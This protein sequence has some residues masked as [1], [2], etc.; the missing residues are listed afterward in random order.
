[1][2]NQTLSAIKRSNK[3]SDQEESSNT[4]CKSEF[5][6]SDSTFNRHKREEEETNVGG[7]HDF[8]SEAFGN[9]GF[10]LFMVAMC[11]AIIGTITMKYELECYVADQ[12][13][14][15]RLGSIFYV[16][17][18]FVLFTAL[19][20]SIMEIITL[21]ILKTSTAT[22]GSLIFYVNE[23]PFSFSAIIGLVSLLC[24]LMGVTGDFRIHATAD[25]KTQLK[26][27]TFIPTTIIFLCFMTLQQCV[28]SN[29]IFS[30]NYSTYL[31]R[32]KRVIFMDLFVSLLARISEF[33][34]KRRGESEES[35]ATIDFER[36]ETDLIDDNPILIARTKTH[37]MKR[38][39]GT[40]I[41][42]GKFNGPEK[43]MT[44]GTKLCLLKEFASLCRYNPRSEISIISIFGKISD[45]AQKKAISICK[46]LIRDQNMR[47]ISDLQFIFK[48]PADFKH[49]IEQIGCK[50]DDQIT[51]KFVEYFIEKC[52]KEKYLISYSLKQLTA[53]VERV[54]VFLKVATF[55]LYCTCI[56]ISATSEFTAVG[57]MASAVFGIPIIASVVKDNVINPI[58][59]LFII[60]PYDVGDRVM[61]TLNGRE[62]NLV[63]SEL[64]VFSTQFFRWDGTSFFVPNNL[65]ANTAIINVRRSG[66]TMEYHH[67]QIS[68]STDHKKVTELK[69]KLQMFVRNH[70]NYFTDYVLVNYDRVENS[71][72]LY[73]KVLMQYK[74]NLQN[75][76]HY[77]NLKSIFISYLNKQVNLLGISYE[78]PLQRVEMSESK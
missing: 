15:I 20:G 8:V 75:H 78:L 29:T 24:I 2:K 40:Y 5:E 21:R 7:F 73:L 26:M 43:S 12:I 39:F 32:I 67:I 27:M 72:K 64:N 51:V 23:S 30:F 70:S 28:V 16:C 9:R 25:A 45:K 14:T 36:E 4:S 59:F 3:L 35:E 37:R 63:V 22:G 49:M 55:F 41:F 34:V 44:F 76:E 33:T 18:V 60:H 65:L 58:M 10:L 19:L 77:L 46:T 71:H 74:T 50:R 66:A 56:Y 6:D 48:N 53:A 17:G 54:A 47:C 52:L 11:L 57:G 13:E 62:E 61:I 68:S 31:R 42:D 1:M 38:K 69:H